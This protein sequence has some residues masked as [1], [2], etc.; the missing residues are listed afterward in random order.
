[1]TTPRVGLVMIVKNEEA[2]LERALR[3]ALPFISTYVI[4][5]TGS[6]DSTKEIVRRVLADVSGLLVDRPW[7]NFGA[8]RSEA[9]ALCDSHM[10]WAIML[11]ADDNLEGQVPP[12]DLWTQSTSMDQ[13]D[14]FAMRIQHGSIW[15]QRVQIFRT[16]RGW[17]YDGVVHESPR[18]GRPMDG[19]SPKIAMLPP[20]TYMVTRCEGARS[21]DPLKYAKDAAL[22]EQELAL[23][24]TDSRTLFYLA[25]SY[26]DAGQKEKA[27]AAY[28]QFLDLSGTWVQEQYMA[29][30]NLLGL[31]ADEE[32]KI[33]LTWKAIDLCPDRAEAPFTLL[34][35]RRTA[36]LP[37]TQQ[38][39]AIATAV[40]NRT[41]ASTLLFMNP[42]IYQWGLD[43]ELAVVAFATKHYKE[44]YDASVRC[45]L[46]AE[47][48]T[49]RENAIKN[50]KAASAALNASR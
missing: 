29:I 8:G 32:E 34:R 18:C 23:K 44:A 13:V 26:R 11:D 33:R 50:A 27:A 39:Y 48:P 47:H 46:G 4:V 40:S 43:D 38:M 31:I 10:D 30:V 20:Q 19:T 9:L 2:V 37:I 41:P 45:I 28:K 12:S 6:T 1:M 42:T 5:D 14:G 21:R 49:L 7:T 36:S 3:S 25:Q 24:P 22:L 35:D 16:G 15:H 17:C